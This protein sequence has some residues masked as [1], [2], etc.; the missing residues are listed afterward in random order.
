M[1]TQTVL[2]NG[3]KFWCRS[4]E[5]ETDEN[6]FYSHKQTMNKEL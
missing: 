6:Y 3:R 4:R 5:Q 2:Y 1:S